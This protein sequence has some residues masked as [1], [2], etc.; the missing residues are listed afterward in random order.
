[1]TP[2][3]DV[4]TLQPSLDN[5]LIPRKDFKMAMRVGESNQYN[6]EN[7]RGRHFIHTGVQSGLSRNTVVQI[8]DDIFSS[9]AGALDRTADALPDD[10][11]PSLFDSVSAAFERR[12]Q[13]L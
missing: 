13:R 2:V 7:I 5:R 4:L 12:L 6:V 1:M 8:F 10:F 3:Y 11:P 9:A